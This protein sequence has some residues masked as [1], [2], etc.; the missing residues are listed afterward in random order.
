MPNEA[1]QITIDHV[2]MGTGWVCF[3]A[4]EQ[5]QSPDR[6]PG[7]LN[8]TFTTWLRRNPEF[9]VRSTLPIAGNGNTVAI[10]VWLD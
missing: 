1:S 6:L 9:K 8:H 3:Q 7:Y 2:E 10:H 4:G 5:S